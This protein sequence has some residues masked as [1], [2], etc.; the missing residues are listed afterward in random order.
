MFRL[1]FDEFPQDWPLRIRTA[2]GHDF[3]ATISN[4]NVSR[5]TI[6]KTHETACAAIIPVNAGRGAQVQT[7]IT[8]R[9][10][11]TK[12]VV[13]VFSP[14]STTDQERI[15]LDLASMQYGVAGQGFGSEF[16]QLDSLENWQ[17]WTA[18]IARSARLEGVRPGCT[19]HVIHELDGW[20]GQCAKRVKERWDK[21]EE[22]HWCG[23]CGRSASR[24]CP[25]KVWYCDPRHQKLAWKYHKN[26]CAT[27]KPQGE[28]QT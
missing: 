22:A 17:A 3:I 26:F 15:V 7:H 13:M 2:R 19:R 25:C 12:H 1:L 28:Q 9:R 18:T 10:L 8:G 24:S 5:F 21:R 6:H 27:R 11:T 14:N 20:F 16:F 23:Q 4:F